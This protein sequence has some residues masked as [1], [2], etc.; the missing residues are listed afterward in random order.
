M[1]H[2]VAFVDGAVAEP[3]AERHSRRRP[4]LSEGFEWALPRRK[5]VDV[6]PELAGVPD[7]VQA[8]AGERVWC[9]FGRRHGVARG[10]LFPTDLEWLGDLPAVDERRRVIES[11]ERRQGQP[12]EA[13]TDACKLSRSCW[14]AQG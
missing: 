4:G 2:G 13:L 7:Q 14:S 6:E 12:V 8:V 9:W 3:I 10:D 1:M 5:A 11:T